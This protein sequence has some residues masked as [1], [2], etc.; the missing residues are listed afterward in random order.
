M[1]KYTIWVAAALAVLT[2]CGVACTP[3]DTHTPSLSGEA[4][5]VIH[6]RRLSFVSEADKQSWIPA[7]AELLEASLAAKASGEFADEEE[8]LEHS[9]VPDSSDCALFD[10]NGDGVAELLL[11]PRGYGGSAGNATYFAFDI[12]TKACIGRLDGGHDGAWCMYYHTPTDK[13]HAI[14]QFWW[15]YGWDQRDRFVKTIDQSGADG[16][17]TDIPYL[18]ILLTAEGEMSDGGDPTARYRVGGQAVSM[19]E[20]Y[21]AYDAFL[22][23]Y[24]RIPETELVLL[25]WEDVAGEGNSPSELAARMAQAL[26]SSKQA[27]LLP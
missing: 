7:L 12:R 23:E 17:Y 4:Y 27:F 24:V 18:E 2:L 26:V 1:K 20:F 6:G 5:T 14:G 9:A 19:D 16:L 3:R 10:V 11:F 15:R 25:S 22:T 8:V 13:T 21:T